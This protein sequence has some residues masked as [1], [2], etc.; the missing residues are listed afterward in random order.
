MPDRRSSRYWRYFAIKRGGYYTGHMIA[1]PAS[2]DSIVA[3]LT[4]K[5]EL[6]LS[7]EYFN[8]DA[9]LAGSLLCFDIDFNNNLYKAH[10]TAV[11]LAN[12]LD[13][14]GIRFISFFSGSKGFHIVVPKLIRGAD[15]VRKC[16]EIK[17]RFLNIIGIDNQIYRANGMLRVEG[18]V[19]QSSGM[20]KIRCNLNLPLERILSKAKLKHDVV[21]WT[22][23]DDSIDLGGLE[24]VRYIKQTHAQSDTDYSNTD[25]VPCIKAMWEDK[26]PPSGTRHMLIYTYAKAM[27][28]LGHTPDEVISM[29]DGHEFWS[30]YSR[31]EYASVIR[32][33]SASGKLA[34]GCKYGVSSDIMQQYCSKLCWFNELLTIEDIL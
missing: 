9:T 22:E 10:A 24:S 31:S 4:D 34:L 33:V 3:H 29:F 2:I 17:K 1:P 30:H 7:I 20:R 25:V 16:K 23:L 5:E 11:R 21:P 12:E 8:A 26:S 32:S 13:N 6:H 19:N 14:M 15:A 27:L 28:R 18:T